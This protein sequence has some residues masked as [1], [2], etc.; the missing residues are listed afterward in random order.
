MANT[1]ISQLPSY[2]GTAA[3]LRWFVMNNSGETE[4]FKYSGYTSPFK[5]GNGT[6]NIVS[7]NNNETDTAGSD[8]FIFG[9]NNTINA[10]GSR[11]VILGG[12]NNGF[13]GSTNNNG[14]IIACSNVNSYF[15]RFV[16]I[17]CDNMSGMENGYA[18]GTSNSLI[19][20]NGVVIGGSFN[21]LT[22]SNGERQYIIGS[23]N[24]QLSGPF[25]RDSAIFGGNDMK[26]Y[27]NG[28]NVATSKA[29]IF[30]AFDTRIEKTNTPSV[31]TKI[32]YPLIIGGQ[33]NKI[34]ADDITMRF[35]PTIISGSGSTLQ[36][37][38]KT[39]ML[40]CWNTTITGGT[41]VVAIGLS[42]TSLSPTD[43]TTYVDNFQVINKVVLRDYTN[44]DFADDTAAAAGGI[45]LGGV[46]HTSGALKIRIT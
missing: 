24:S 36:D 19:S 45:V 31:G 37:V 3:D 32:V 22:N 17:G 30:G 16:A 10:G 34:W 9:V 28:D 13:V 6:N 23:T 35:N 44:L 26:I 4:T 8:N 15:S 18:F 12:E 1:K 40:N 38:E 7:I 5:A 20:G 39:T 41:N 21:F 14:A 33:S 29:Q 27:N 25:Y 11:S 43:N 42:G 46:Y 2:T